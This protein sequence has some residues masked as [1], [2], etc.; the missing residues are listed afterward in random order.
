M[1]LIALLVVSLF[2]GYFLVDIFLGSGVRYTLP[3]IEIEDPTQPPAILHLAVLWGIKGKSAAHVK[4][5]TKSLS[6]TDQRDLLCEAAHRVANEGKALDVASYELLLRFLRQKDRNIGIELLNT[7]QANGIEVKPRHYQ[8]LVRLALN[9]RRADVVAAIMET[10]A[11][12]GEEAEEIIFNLREKDRI[13]VY[14]NWPCRPKL[15]Q[16]ACAMLISAYSRQERYDCV[17]EIVETM[18]AEGVSLNMS[19]FST[20]VSTLKARR[21]WSQL[22]EALNQMDES[23]LD[24]AGIIGLCRI[25]DEVSDSERLKRMASRCNECSFDGHVCCTLIVSLGKLQAFD[26]IRT[27]LCN[28]RLRL[29]SEEW[30]ASYNATITAFAKAGRCVEALQALQELSDVGGSPDV[31]SYSAAINACARSRDCHKSLELLEQMKANG[32]E[33]NLITYNSTITA[34]EKS[35][36]CELALQVVEMVRQSPIQPDV[37]TFNAAIA[38]CAHGGQWE[39]ALALRDEMVNEGFRLSE[40]TYS[41]LMKCFG[42]SGQY[43]RAICVLDEMRESDVQPD[44]ACYNYA[45]H[46]CFAGNMH[47]KAREIM[48]EMRRSHVQPDPTSYFGMLKS[49]MGVEDYPRMREVWAEMK[50]LRALPDMNC[51]S[52]M[53][54]LYADELDAQSIIETLDEM[55]MRKLRMTQKCYDCAVRGL[56]AATGSGMYSHP[57]LD[58]WSNRRMGAFYD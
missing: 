56:S 7:M 8:P 27:M 1:I 35:K 41:S 18:K 30:T 40:M 29:P 43:D 52:I 51:Y 17:D 11:N 44:R 12:L 15:S 6:V 5:L 36:Q 21:L 50:T 46:A 20:Y 48:E 9:S 47:E 49:Y 28:L 58:E 3:D 25:C 19:S 13:T 37:I 16:K 31:I 2:G 34:C 45:L 57:L 42:E 54:R 32:V 4:A 10:T 26:E 22:Q 23:T 14:E 55:K 39:Q 24:T 33:P 38:A 53:L